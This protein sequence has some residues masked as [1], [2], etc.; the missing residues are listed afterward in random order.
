VPRDEIEQ[1]VQS[2]RHEGY[3]MLRSISDDPVVPH[4]LPRIIPDLA[5]ES[6]R[7]GDGSPLDGAALA[8]SGLRDS[9]GVTVA[10]IQ[11]ADGTLAVSPAGA[12]RLV[13]GDVVLLL[14]R[15]DALRQAR[16]AFR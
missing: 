11:R 5:L 14:G 15:R 12:E 10:A 13:T 9:Y 1:Q 2:I 8:T 4:T 16:S 3:E 7:V 6:Y